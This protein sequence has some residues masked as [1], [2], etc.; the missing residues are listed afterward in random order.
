MQGQ[1]WVVRTEEQ[2]N[3]AIRQ[4]REAPLPL[5]AQF[6]PIIHP[7]TLKQVRYAHS[8]CGAL[9]AYNQTNMEVAKKDAKVAYGVI[10]VCSSIITGERTARLKS[11]RDYTKEEMEAFCTQMEQYLTENEI[12]FTPCGE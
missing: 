11:F 9:A 4:L 3:N 1:H 10:T 6:G 8:L 12:P 7:K 2:R 5:S